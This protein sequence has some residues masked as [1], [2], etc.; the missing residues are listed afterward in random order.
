MST[1]DPLAPLGQALSDIQ[2]DQAS[3]AAAVAKLSADIS[4]LLP[5]VGSGNVEVSGTTLQNLLSQAQ[6]IHT[7]LGGTLSAVQ[8]EDSVVNPPAAPPATT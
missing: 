4:A 5:V 2:A 6:A 1:T 3:I 7:A 8:A